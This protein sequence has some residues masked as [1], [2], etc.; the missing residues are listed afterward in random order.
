MKNGRI[1][2]TLPEGYGNVGMILSNTKR[3]ITPEIRGSKIKFKV[4]L[5]GEGSLNENNTP[6]DVGQPKNLELVTKAMEKS[7]ETQVR[8]FLSKIQKQYKVDIV[9]FGQEIYRKEPKQWKTL[10]DQWDKKFPEAEVSIE[11]KISI[12]GSG[13]AGAPLH[14]KE[15]EIKK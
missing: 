10:K 1:T 8:K 4:E 12:R 13:M 7:V 3:T 15:K 11:V 6:L 14:L 9:G 2:A 5:Q